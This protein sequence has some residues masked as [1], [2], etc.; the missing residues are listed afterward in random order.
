MTIPS[1]LPPHGVRRIR[2]LSVAGSSGNEFVQFGMV[3]G[4]FGDGETLTGQLGDT[5]LR[6]ASCLRTDASHADA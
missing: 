3:G 6:D 1:S 5:R 2:W 4:P